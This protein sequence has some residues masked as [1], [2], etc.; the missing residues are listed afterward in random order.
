MPLDPRYCPQCG[1]GDLLLTIPDGDTRLR[2]CCTRCAHVIYQN[3]LV[4]GGAILEWEGR[5]LFCQRAIEPR[6]GKWTLPAGFMENRETVEECV[7]R[8]CAEEATA[9]IDDMRLFSVY[10]LP[11]VSQV[12]VM[13]SGTLAGG[14][15]AAGEESSCVELMTPQEIPWDEIAF[16]VIHANL[17]LYLAQGSEPAPVHTGTVYPKKAR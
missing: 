17:E 11:H 8:E 1:A 10:S 7:R 5:I 9:E 4:V 2:Y 12:Y 15:A 14:R 13:Y 16:E 3:P 6:K